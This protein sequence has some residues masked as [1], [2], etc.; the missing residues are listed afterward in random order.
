VVAELLAET[1]WL[2]SLYVVVQ[3]VPQNNGCK[4]YAIMP[5]LWRKAKITIQFTDFEV[6]FHYLVLKFKVGFR[7]FFAIRYAIFMS[8][9]KLM[10]WP[11]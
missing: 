1:P 9:Q 3:T 7:R 2:K 8:S 4:P 6:E 5:S 11:A 10:R